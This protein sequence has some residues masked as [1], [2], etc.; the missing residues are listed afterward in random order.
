MPG[1]ALP[2]RSPPGQSGA[3][4]AKKKA[5][6]QRRAENQA[7]GE[8]FPSARCRASVVKTAAAVWFCVHR[9]LGL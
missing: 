2:A 6:H 3:G 9:L 5:R 1:R 4:Q 7:D 8:A